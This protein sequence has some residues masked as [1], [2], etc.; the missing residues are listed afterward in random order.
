MPD[1]PSLMQIYALCQERNVPV[2]THS[3]PGGVW[4]Y[5]FTDTD[6]RRVGHPRNYKKILTT[7]PE[8]RICLA[9]F[10]GAEEWEKHLTNPSQGEDAAWVRYITDMI[11]S[12]DYPNL[13]TDISYTM[14]TVRQT[15]STFDYTEYLKV[16]LADSRIRERVLFGSD[17][18]MIDL[19]TLSEK[20]LAV[21]LR[22]RIG[23]AWFFQIAHHNPKRY[24]GLA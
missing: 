4:A 3:S 23:E 7:F 18:Y 15:Q 10:G 14:F 19:E 5:R 6:R 24:L 13:Y 1:H 21:S 12:G 2:M 22:S 9:H 8:L 17:F 16:L 11:R 20:Q